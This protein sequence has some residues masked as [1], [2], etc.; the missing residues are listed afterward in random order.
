MQTCDLK[1]NFKEGQGEINKDIQPSPLACVYTFTTHTRALTCL[2][3]T[4]SARLWSCQLLGPWTIGPS[5]DYVPPSHVCEAD[6]G[7]VSRLFPFFLPNPSHIWGTVCMI[8][9]L[10]VFYNKEK[11]VALK[12]ATGDIRQMSLGL[13]DREGS[14]SIPGHQKKIPE[15]PKSFSNQLTLCY[16]FSV[17][18]PP[19]APVFEH[20]CLPTLSPVCTQMTVLFGKFITHLKG[21]GSLEGDEPL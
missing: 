14:G 11:D 20:F 10:T 9:F 19:K 1:Q 5:G 18:W 3:I 17:K 15:E 6:P 7:V 2:Q 16:S 12:V 4:R 13:W 8:S 21:G